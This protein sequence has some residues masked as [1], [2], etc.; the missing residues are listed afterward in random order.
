MKARSGSISHFHFGR[1]AR[2]DRS[3][4]TIGED[5]PRLGVGLRPRSFAAASNPAPDR[6]SSPSATSTGRCTAPGP[7]LRA[8]THTIEHEHLVAILERPAVE[9]GD[10]PKRL[11]DPLGGERDYENPVKAIRRDLYPPGSFCR[12]EFAP[13][14]QL[15]VNDRAETIAPGGSRS[16]P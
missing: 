10:R 12:I 14:P 15:V 8:S 6:S 16:R 1:L 11:T 4:E 2:L 3:G 13:D 5:A 7:I 9:G